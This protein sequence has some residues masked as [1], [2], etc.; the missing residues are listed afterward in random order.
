MPRAYLIATHLIFGDDPFPEFFELKISPDPVQSIDNV[1]G[2]I[3]SQLMEIGGDTFLTAKEELIKHICKTP[4]LA[5]AA[6]WVCPGSEFQK[7]RS[8]MYEEMKERIEK[9]E[10]TNRINQINRRSKNV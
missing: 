2:Q 7:Y 8:R 4:W 6:K 5:W 3:H 9:Q 10:L 1:P